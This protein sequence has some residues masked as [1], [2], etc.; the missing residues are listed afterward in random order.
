MSEPHACGC[1]PQ[2]GVRA[3]LSQLHRRE[4][5]R[6]GPSMSGKGDLRGVQE[7]LA[8]RGKSARNGDMVG[9]E[10]VRKRNK[11]EAKMVT[12]LTRNFHCPEIT[13]GNMLRKRAEG[14]WAAGD[15]A[16][17]RCKRGSR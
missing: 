11:S 5:G 7:R 4:R 1:T 3:R 12:R 2:A 16:E 14:L 9:E 17:L 6:K 10:D 8:K 13:G 15:L